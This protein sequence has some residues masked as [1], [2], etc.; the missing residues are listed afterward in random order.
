MYDVQRFNPEFKAGERRHTLVRRLTDLSI[1]TGA[2]TMLIAFLLTKGI[3]YI[4]QSTVQVRYPLVNELLPIINKLTSILQHTSEACWVATSLLLLVFWIV[5]S[6]FSLAQKINSRL[7]DGNA[8]SI[9]RSG[10]KLPTIK[11][12]HVKRSLFSIKSLQ[13][14]MSLTSLDVEHFDRMAIGRLITGIWFRNLSVVDL[15]TSVNQ[16]TATIKIENSHTDWQIKAKSFAEFQ[17]KKRG[18]FL[19]DKR[20]VAD[21]LVSPHLL[22]AGKTRSGKTMFLV[23]LLASHLHVTRKEQDVP[24]EMKSVV[25]MIDPKGQDFA[26]FKNVPNVVVGLDPIAIFKQVE[27]FEQHMA[28]RME[29]LGETGQRW[30]DVFESSIMV[31]DEYASIGVSFGTITDKDLAKQY[32]AKEFNAMMLRLISRSASSGCFIVVSIV[33][34][35]SGLLPTNVRAQFLNRLAMRPDTESITFMF[36]N[37]AKELTTQQFSVGQG[38]YGDVLTRPKLVKTPWLDFDWQ[39][40]LLDLFNEFTSK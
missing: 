22:V 5:P 16:I 21:W 18:T 2:I 23:H 6:R 17:P 13:I 27:A 40:P 12:S 8:S 19:I 11:I 38:V 4:S 26:R 1:L 39:A 31:L 15:T 28:A 33:Q 14:D 35:D 25:S 7:L 10:M 29:Y 34:P 24:D 9:M 3:A 32:S 36:D 30:Q 20:T 37:D